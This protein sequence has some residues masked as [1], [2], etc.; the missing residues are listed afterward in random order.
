[1]GADDGQWSPG[2][3]TP[4]RHADGRPKVSPDETSLFGL[5]AVWSEVASSSESPPEP[6]PTSR[7][8]RHSARPAK[9]PVWP[10][11]VLIIAALLCAVVM[12]WALVNF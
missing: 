12:I 4:Y 9:R 3:S 7:R 1:M 2:K 11:A 6:A 10:V 8:S 5:N